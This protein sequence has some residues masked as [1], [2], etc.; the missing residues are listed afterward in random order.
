MR[1]MCRMG[2]QGADGFAEVLTGGGWR[3]VTKT[4]T[5]SGSTNYDLDMPPY[6]QGMALLRSVVP[7]RRVLLSMPEN[8]KEYPG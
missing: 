1:R 3:A 8:A 6:V 2:A 7:N 4:G 5:S